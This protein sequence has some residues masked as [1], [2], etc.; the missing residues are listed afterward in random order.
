MELA[1]HTAGGRA[2]DW[3]VKRA[4][5]IPRGCKPPSPTYCQNGHRGS[6]GYFKFEREQT[7]TRSA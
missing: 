5:T 6:C 7:R 4:G 2:P 1:S 3:P